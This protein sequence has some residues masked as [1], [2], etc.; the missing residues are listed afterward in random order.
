M[1]LL[2]SE[3][4]GRTPISIVKILAICLCLSTSSIVGTMVFSFYSFMVHDLI[5]GTEAEVIGQV[6]FLGVTILHNLF[7]LLSLVIL[8]IFMEGDLSYFLDY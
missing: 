7:L 2:C 4:E 1:N 6:I 3:K 5:K 8:L